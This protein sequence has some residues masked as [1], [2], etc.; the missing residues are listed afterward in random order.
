[1]LSVAQVLELAGLMPDRYRA[2]VLV[3]TFGCL[4]WGEVTALER[5]DL[6]VDAMTVRVR[7]Q[8]NEVRGLGLVLGPP[9]SR[10]GVRTVS[11][12]AAIGPALLQHL[13]RHVGEAA[14][15]LVFTV[16][17]GKPIWRGNFNPLVGW[18]KAVAAVGVPGLHFHDLRHSG[19][20][21]ASRTGT[22]L[23]D[24]IARMGHDS[25]RAAL[26]YQHR[27]SEADR[28]IAQAVNQQLEAEQRAAKKMR[29]DAGEGAQDS[30]AKGRRGHA[31]DGK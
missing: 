20:T 28:A 2:L 15:A 21:L 31:E 5:R 8:F 7:Q 14:S 17:S 10:A 4:R 29:R 30:P 6:D 24:L 26:I 12:P 16:P 9:K 18:P 1:M 27:T 3:A 25:P 23:R 13:D 22:S 19:N 11:L